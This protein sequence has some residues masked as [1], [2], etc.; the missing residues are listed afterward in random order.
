LRRVASLLRQL[1]HGKNPHC[2]AVVTAGTVVIQE[3]GKPRWKIKPL[4]KIT[5]TNVILQIIK[6]IDLIKNC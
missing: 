1:V 5:K 4:F 2:F 3:V 6:Q